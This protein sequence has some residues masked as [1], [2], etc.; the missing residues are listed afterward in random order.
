MHPS[1]ADLPNENGLGSVDDAVFHVVGAG[2]AYEE[3]VE[4]LLQVI[5]LGI[6]PHGEGEQTRRRPAPCCRGRSEV[7][8][9][10]WTARM[11]KKTES[12][13]VRHSNSLGRRAPRY[14]GHLRNWTPSPWS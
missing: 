1:E 11:P 5:K 7:A 6:V 8:C 13:D 4:R 14:P 10:R 3:T 9:Q 12:R 2:N